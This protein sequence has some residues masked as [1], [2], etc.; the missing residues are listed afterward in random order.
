MMLFNQ[1][2]VDHFF[3]VIIKISSKDK[4]SAKVDEVIQTATCETDLRVLTL[5]SE[6]VK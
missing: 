6:K 5:E 2:F 4:L 3:G 1:H